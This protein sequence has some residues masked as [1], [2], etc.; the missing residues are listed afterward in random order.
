MPDA[1]EVVLQLRW[2][3][4]D[5]G[6][7]ERVAVDTRDGAPAVEAQ[8]GGHVE[9]RTA[10]G[11]TYLVRDDPF[12]RPCRVHQAADPAGQ[13]VAI[14]TSQGVPGLR[15]AQDGEEA[16]LEFAALDGRVAL[17]DASGRPL[18]GV[19]RLAPGDDG[20]A[21]RAIAL[22]AHVSRWLTL[23]ELRSGSP[24]LAGA[25]EVTMA[26]PGTEPGQDVDLATTDN[27][28]V[29]IT[30]LGSEPLFVALLVLSPDWSADVAVWDDQG[31]LPGESRSAILRLDVL[32]PG[33]REG[34][35]RVIGLAARDAFDPRPLA[36]PA[37]SVASPPAVIPFTS[38][39]GT[40][41]PGTPGLD[42]EF[43][44]MTGA[45]IPASPAPRYLAWT[46]SDLL[47]RV[48][49][50]AEDAGQI[51]PPGTS[52]SAGT[53]RRL[54]VTIATAPPG[55]PSLAQ[56][57]AG[58]ELLADELAG[59]GLEVIRITGEEATGARVRE[60]IADLHRR[61]AADNGADLLMLYVAGHGLTAEGGRYEVMLADGDRLG[62]VEFAAVFG[63]ARRVVVIFDADQGMHAADALVRAAAAETGSSDRSI[64]LLWSPG[65]DPSRSADGFAEALVAALARTG[66]IDDNLPAA[67]H[68]R[69]AAGPG[70][71]DAIVRSF[72]P[73]IL[74]P[75]LTAIPA[76]SYDLAGRL[77]A[78]GD[79]TGARD[80]YRS[81]YDA[82]RRILG[83]EHASTL[84]CASRLADTERALGDHQ[85][86]REL[87]EENEALRRRLKDEDGPYS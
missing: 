56:L 68:E 12:Q 5:G 27:A 21:A 18:A 85:A 41:Y 16:E 42:T 44:I 46:T 3:S 62:E 84:A 17:A 77:K 52:G 37:I 33:Q 82:Q 23:A 49:R 34:H 65:T 29:A 35:A 63:A 36:L 55:L 9:V 7:T 59:R 20:F 38:P 71:Q 11:V 83:P 57:E 19:P 1:A 13:L 69:L 28:T 72:G 76:T 45:T 61:A 22:A 66:A 47:V 78:R 64:A 67:L 87:D 58:T 54:L 79:L 60:T 30:N 51:W 48:R 6:T 39:P 4:A 14:L 15:L 40:G 74:L 31:L 75:E 10:G 24:L 2:P 86:A 25:V 81:T 53:G 70:G 80:L 8:G 26:G 73:P 50:P 43:A 32:G